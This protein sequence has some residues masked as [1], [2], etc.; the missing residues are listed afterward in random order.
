MLLVEQ[1]ISCTIAVVTLTAS[2]DMLS[3]FVNITRHPT[4]IVSMWLNLV[5]YSNKVA[6]L[7]FVAFVSTSTCFV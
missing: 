6:L 3:F 7:K 4:T 5:P 2:L 1:S